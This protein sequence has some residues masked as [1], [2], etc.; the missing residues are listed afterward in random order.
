MA[1]NE[2]YL[3]DLEAAST[4]IPADKPYVMMNMMKFRPV[5]QYPADFKGRPSTSLSGRQ[6]YMIYRDAF[7]KRAAE[8]GIPSAVVLFLGEAHTNITAGPHEGEAWDFIL[9]VRFH[10]FAAFRSVLEDAVYIN[11]IQPHRV[12]AVLDFRS[13]GVTEKRDL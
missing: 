4:R 12:A 5:A 6:A 10:N 13:F 3:G 8:L 11:D 2:L 1:N 9:L 7:T